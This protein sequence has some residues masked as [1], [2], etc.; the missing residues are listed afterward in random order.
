MITT[1]KHLQLTIDFR[2]SI[3][4]VPSPLPDGAVDP[5]DPEYNAM[6]ARLLEAVKSHPGVLQRYLH[7][8]IASQMSQ[9]P[10]YHWQ[11]AIM[12][13]DLPYQIILAPAIETLPV[14]DQ[15]WFIEGAR[16][17]LFEEYVDMFMASFAVTEDRPMIRE[18][19]E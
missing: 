10:Y 16:L 17:D 18:V 9:H 6:Q 12:G 7:S 8:L 15:A 5:P 1:T 19:E 13:S 14:E 11:D 3:A 2:I 4:D